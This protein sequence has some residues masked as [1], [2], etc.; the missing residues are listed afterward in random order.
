MSD[1][2]CFMITAECHNH[3]RSAGYDGRAFYSTDCVI[4]QIEDTEGQTIDTV[5]GEAYRKY[6]YT[7]GQRIKGEKIFFFDDL[8]YCKKF[9]ARIEYNNGWKPTEKM[10]DAYTA[11]QMKAIEDPICRICA[12]LGLGEEALNDRFEDAKL[13]YFMEAGFSFETYQKIQDWLTIG[14]KLF[15]PL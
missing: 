1:A 4:L 15:L 12:S 3:F 9:I 5:D 8:A 7:V 6:V 2:K 10:L 14:Q 13:G 11:A